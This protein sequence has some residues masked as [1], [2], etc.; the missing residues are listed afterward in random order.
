MYPCASLNS[1]WHNRMAQIRNFERT[2][3]AT[4][5]LLTITYALNFNN[6]IRSNAIT[7]PSPNSL[8]ST[9]T[10]VNKAYASTG[11]P[12]AAGTFCFHV[13][14]PSTS[15]VILTIQLSTKGNTG[16][17]YRMEIV[18]YTPLSAK[19]QI[20]LNLW[21]V[22]DN[23]LITKN[24][25]QLPGSIIGNYCM[26]WQVG[27]NAAWYY[28]G[29]QILNHSMADFNQPLTPEIVTWGGVA[30]AGPFTVGQYG[31]LSI[32][33]AYLSDLQEN[34]LSPNIKYLISIN[35]SSPPSTVPL[36]TFSPTKSK[37]SSISSSTAAPTVAPIQPSTKSPSI[38]PSAAPIQYTTTTTSL[39]PS[40]ISST[41]SSRFPTA[42]PSFV[43]QFT[44]LSTNPS[45]SPTATPSFVPQ[46]TIS[47]N[48]STSST[49]A[50]SEP[51]I[52]PSVVNS[53]KPFNNPS[54][55]P[56][57]KP[58]FSPSSNPTF[59]PS[60]APTAPTSRPTIRTTHTPTAPT[61]RP[62][63]TPIA[64][65]VI[66]TVAPSISSA[67][68]TSSLINI[69]GYGPV[70][71]LKLKNKATHLNNVV[72]SN[73]GFIIRGY[74]RVYFGS[75]N[76]PLVPPNHGIFAKFNLLGKKFSYTVDLSNV[77]CGCNAG[78][79]VV[80]MPSRNALGVY[81]IGTDNDY[82]CDANKGGGT[83]CPEYDLSESNMY[84]M[85]STLHSCTASR[86][87][88]GYYP[89]CDRGGCGT[90]IYEKSASNMCP[91]A[92]CTIDT[93]KPFQVAHALHKS[94]LVP[95]GS[96]ASLSQITIHISQD[97]RSIQ[98]NVCGDSAYFES[99]SGVLNG[100][101]GFVSSLWSGGPDSMTFLD[102]MTGC[103]ET[104]NISTARVSFSNF[105]L[106]KL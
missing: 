67:G 51:T 38:F 43:K 74:G 83:F 9:F 36:S 71:V 8:V 99:M 24:R 20:T 37:T 11:I 1:S 59:K 90:N 104:C 106:T 60:T 78:A 86:T 82:Y 68:K 48:P 13:I 73:N 46:S 17:T 14:P 97:K 62:S 70:Y 69:V 76:L 21:G 66:P 32:S 93:R 75:E 87:V 98:Y 18:W 25:Q 85:A 58:S 52:I 44:T 80:Q 5:F 91:A 2:F 34:S 94:P 4:I 50:F 96:A 40:T 63:V 15:G 22:L 23:N 41:N 12:Q 33:N 57:N 101:M 30:A 45:L 49:V 35:P 88:A 55:C 72:V 29:E 84:S 16:A 81:A 89:T 61:F 3:L 54:S 95:A 27:N 65:P 105:S 7:V 31:S 6:W 53:A 79:Y 28:N 102:G 47:S 92:T 56:S 26:T 39:A 77:G 19:N 42:T 10:L 103:T 100:T 64:P